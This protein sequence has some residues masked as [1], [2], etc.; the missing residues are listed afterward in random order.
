MPWKTCMIHGRRSENQHEQ[1][2]GRRWFQS[3]WVTLNK[4]SVEKVTADAVEIARELESEEEPEDVV[5]LLPFHDK[6]LID[7]VLLLM[8][9]Q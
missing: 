4:T 7:K 8:D 3:S 9:E 6:D 2:F 1:E 5:E